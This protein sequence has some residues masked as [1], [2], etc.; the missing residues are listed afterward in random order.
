MCQKKITQLSGSYSYY[1]FNLDL[2]LYRKRDFVGI[3]NKKNIEEWTFTKK[4]ALCRTVTS[5]RKGI[6]R[7]VRQRC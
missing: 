7:P 2:F 3:I 1:D 5:L 4:D 6:L